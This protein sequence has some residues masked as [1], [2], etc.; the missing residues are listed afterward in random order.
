MDEPEEPERGRLEAEPPEAEPP[1]AEPPEAEPPEAEP[2]EAE[3]PEAEPPEAEPPEAE[4]LEAEPPEAEPPE[5][6]PLKAEPLKAE[7]RPR[8]S[9]RELAGGAGLL[10]APWRDLDLRRMWRILLHAVLIGAMA[11]GF[12]VLFFYALEWTSWFTL[13]HLARLGLPRAGGEMGLTPPVEPDASRRW[14]VLWLPALGGLG[15]GLLVHFLAPTAGGPGGDAYIDAF[16]NRRGRMGKRV[17]FAKALA[18]LLTIGTGGAAGREGPTL[19]V[20]AGMSSLFSRLLDLD[21]R[22]RRILLAAGAAAG[23]GA[24]FRTPLG[25]ALFA[26]EILYRDDFEADAIIPCIVASVTGYSIVTMV[27]GPGSLFILPE[28]YTFV[29]QALPLYALMAVG[30]SFFGAVYVKLRHGFR[31]HVLAALTT[32]A[33]IRPA[34]GGLLLGILAFFIPRVLGTGYGLVQEALDHADWIVGSG[35]GYA[36]LFGIALAKMLAVSLTVSSGGSGGDIGPGFVIGGLVGAAFGLLFHDLAPNLAPQPAAFALVGMGAFVGGIAHA[37]ISSLIMVCELAGSYDLLAPLMLAEA[38]AFVVLRRVAIYDTQ[39]PGRV[40]SPAHRHE[41]TVDI[42]R[43]VRVRDVYHPELKLERVA[44]S[45]SAREVLARL[46][47]TDLPAVMVVTGQ[48]A[49]AGIVS[50]ETAQVLLAEEALDGVVAA[51]MLM[52]TAELSLTDD[53]HTALHAFLEVDAVVLP[54]LDADTG[55]IV[56]VLTHA[57]VDRAYEAAVAERFEEGD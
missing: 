45:T 52:P 5:A 41:L 34:L 30:I 4:P 51:D 32:P 48:G 24:M 26:I 31:D 53:L 17:P 9:L 56:G 3:P 50:I 12:A 39:V 38:V 21:E 57:D 44:P 46:G 16:H 14:I 29:P 25:G 20:S 6:E 43:A 19:Q 22:E 35:S 49:V 37:P 23:T 10:A 13:D 42:L 11:G 47:R 15:C 2:P 36:M 8:L 28:S 27:F 40:H 7:L 33:W 54:I 55:E 1:E 18:S